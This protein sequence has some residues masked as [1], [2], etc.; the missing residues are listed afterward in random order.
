MP[1]REPSVPPVE[2][3]AKPP[4]RSF[5]DKAA[6]WWLV[7][8]TVLVVGSFLFF[9]FLLSWKVGVSW[10]GFWLVTAIT[11]TAVTRVRRW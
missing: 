1:Y 10:L 11:A 7:L 6:V 2:T 8:I 9:P 3:E 4:K 5:L